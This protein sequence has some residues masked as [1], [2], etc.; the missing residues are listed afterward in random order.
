RERTTLMSNQNLSMLDGK[1]QLGM[2]L[3]FILNRSEGSNQGPSSLRFNGANPLYNYGQLVDDAG[4]ATGYYPGIRESFA[5][6]AEQAG[7]LS[8]ELNPLEELELVQRNTREED[9]R[10]NLSA[11][12]QL[13]SGL[14][15]EVY[16]QFWKGS[17]EDENLALPGSYAARD[18][19]NR[20]TQRDSTG[21]LTYAVPRGAILDLSSGQSR[22]NNFRGIL[23]LDREVGKKG[24]INGLAGYEVK[25]L[26]GNGSTN[27]YYGYNPETG[28][29]IPVDYEGLHALYIN[30]SR[31]A[32]IPYSDGVSG[33]ADNFL[34]S[35]I[36][37]SYSYDGRY[38]VSFSGRR[39]ASNLFG[40]KT[41]QKTVPLW[42]TG[43]AWNLTGESWELPKWVD[44]LRIRTT[45]GVNGNVNKN[46][47]AMTTSRMIGT[48]NYTSLPVGNL[49]SPPNPKL[50]WEKIRIL[51]LGTDFDLVGNRLSG[52]FEFYRKQG[53][54]L[55]GDLPF[56]PNTG[57]ERFRGN[58]ANTLTKGFDLQL[59]G[60]VIDRKFR[61]QIDYFHSHVREKVEQYELESTVQD[62]LGQA[63]GADPSSPI[64]PLEG[65]PVYAVYSLPFVGLDPNTGDPQ[66]YLDGE[67]ST[68]YATIIN[69]ASTQ[70]MTY[71][72]AARPTHFG[73]FRN[74][75][76]WGNW[77]LSA[78]VVYRL[79]YYYR[80]KSVR[81]ATVL[82]GV[83]GHGDFSQRWQQPG[84][85]VFTQVPSLPGSRNTF[86]D[87]F[88]SY[89]S[90]LV[91]KGDHVRLQDVRL[92]YRFQEL[93]RSGLGSLELFSYANNLGIIWKSSDDPL[94]P[95]FRT[96]KPLRSLTLGLRLSY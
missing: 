70:D 34:S 57:V 63:A 80:R 35:F 15:A 1:L 67:V 12:Y 10:L 66:G 41:N 54:D 50:R 38:T 18:L 87:S 17:S 40:V 45:Y 74:T 68:D 71:H 16:Y 14:T 30:P 78:N 77:S 28:I 27:R 84:D 59:T 72:G 6:G 95:D 2:G 91:E 43:L 82:T 48:S 25:T 75:F 56:A 60:V 49:I 47:A 86:R 8:W 13:I 52:T 85:E 53:E 21:R 83:Q 81:Y 22:S 23:R 33:M 9:V 51:N 11:T 64:F 3:N 32:R 5:Q 88:Y 79:G 69:T 19:I 4:N 29:S 96:M 36:N 39:D 31:S 24:Q 44:Y 7:L 65:R 90:V 20:Y 26:R 62:Y 58:F 89:S 55:I 94:D 73:S 76:S 93:G 37:G 46:V 61:W 42:S 92:S